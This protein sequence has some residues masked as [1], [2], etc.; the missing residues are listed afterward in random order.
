MMAGLPPREPTIAEQREAL[1]RHFDLAAV[2]HGERSAG[3]RMRK[4][5]IKFARHHPAQEEV[6]AAFIRCT[7]PQEWRSVIDHHYPA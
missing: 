5:G 2:I 3:Q 4:F 7:T 1:L 6:K